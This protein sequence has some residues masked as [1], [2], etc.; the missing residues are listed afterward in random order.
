MARDEGITRH[1]SERT[2]RIS[3]RARISWVGTDGERR[4]RSKTFRTAA[5][6]RKWRRE[7]LAAIDAG[8]YHEAPP[9][10]VAEVAAQWLATVE[11]GRAAS[12]LAVYRQVW[13]KHLAPVFGHRK[14]GSV[15]ATEVQALL[16]RLA[17]DYRPATVRQVHKVLAGVYG[18][19]VTDGLVR[20]NPT[21]DRRL[22]SERRD[23]PRVWSAA[24]VRQFI[25]AVESEPHG[26]LWVVV[27]TTGLRIGEALALA[28]KDV[29]LDAR[30]AYI[31]RTAQR[32]AD[33]WRISELTKTAQAR[34]VALPASA[35]L[36]LHRQRALELPGPLAFPAIDGTLADPHTVRRR[37]AVLCERAGVPPLTP[38]GLRK[39]AATML[40]RGGV[41]VHAAARQ[42]G[43]TT[44]VALR[45]YVS[46]GIDAQ[47]IAADAVDAALAG[48]AARRNQG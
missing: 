10:T 14:I 11:A 3:W 33:R 4:H 17:R 42:L 45:F 39:T 26:H 31:H 6:A 43:H 24:E 23:P 18:H 12:T 35:V 20:V 5:A 2:G 16:D 27:V 44:D 37:L 34:T 15:T 46:L 29:D 22:P 40:A 38:H 9:V 13:H 48:D 7:Q 21:A 25:G 41:N 28:W 1:E 30:T 19:A 32:T 8:T 36:A 47:E